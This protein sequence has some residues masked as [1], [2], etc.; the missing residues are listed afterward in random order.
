MTHRIY[1]SEVHNNITLLWCK[2]KTNEEALLEELQLDAD[3]TDRLG[4]MTAT[5]RRCEWLTTRWLLKQLHPQSY[6][7]SYHQ[8]GKPYVVDAPFEIGITHSK[9]YVALAISYNNRAVGIDCETF[10]ERIVKVRSKFA[11][12]RELV[13]AS[14]NLIPNLTLVW[15][16][17][18]ALYKHYEVGNVDFINDMEINNFEFSSQGGTC[19]G[20]ITKTATTHQLSYK[21]IDNTVIMWVS[22]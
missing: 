6:K 5:H 20:V 10:S 13:Q 4:K 18:E 9:D 3:D 19:S 2:H 7:I 11:S 8:S 17:K 16:A 14:T 15:C 22:E 12:R 21:I 1:H